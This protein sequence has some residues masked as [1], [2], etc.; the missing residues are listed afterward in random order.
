MI[1][2]PLG[3]W[4][5]FKQFA[6]KLK[7][8]SQLVAQ[9]TVQLCGSVKTLSSSYPNPP[10]HTH[11]CSPLCGSVWIDSFLQQ[12]QFY[13]CV[14]ENQRA[15]QFRASFK[16]VGGQESWNIISSWRS[17]RSGALYTSEF[18]SGHPHGLKRP[19]KQWPSVV[20]NPQYT[21]RRGR[22]P[23]FHSWLTWM[24]ESTK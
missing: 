16:A 24:N 21:T 8:L 5:V 20:R 11:T 14:M 23:P 12:L 17:Q 22:L 10:P 13:G 1:W 9:P 7:S 15:L 6:I 2:M 19:W 4:G 18:H 3:Q